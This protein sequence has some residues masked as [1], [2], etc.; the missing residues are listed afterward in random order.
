MLKKILFTAEVSLMKNECFNLQSSS[1]PQLRIY[2][3]WTFRNVL[4]GESIKIFTDSLD[5][6]NI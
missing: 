2:S 5:L 4:W 6:R 1:F 3:F